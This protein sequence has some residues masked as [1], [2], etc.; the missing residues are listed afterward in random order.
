M[1]L[2]PTT[3]AVCQH[4]AD[5][6]TP[7][8]GTKSQGRMDSI[9]MP[10]HSFTKQGSTVHCHVVC[11]MVTAGIKESGIHERFR[12]SMI[13]CV[14]LSDTWPTHYLLSIGSW[15]HINWGQ[16]KPSLCYECWTTFSPGP[17]KHAHGSCSF[18]PKRWQRTSTESWQ[19]S[20][21]A[22]EIGYRPSRT[23]GRGQNCQTTKT[24]MQRR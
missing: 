3:S 10:C 6:I 20:R 22:I 17:R 18:P 21:I 8:T 16:A 2:P 13:L 12:V 23:A 15:W 19:P 5:Q 14:Q 7:C 9:S 4:G 1:F 24:R 11:K